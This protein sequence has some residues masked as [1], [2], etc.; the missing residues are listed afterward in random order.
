M[1]HGVEPGQLLLLADTQSPD[2]V[3]DPEHDGGGDDHPRGDGG[4]AD[5]LHAEQRY[6]ST[7][8][9]TPVDR[10]E[11]DGEDTPD[12][13]HPVH[14]D[15]AHRVVDTD[16]L[17][18]H[19]RDHHH[20]TSDRSDQDRTEGAD[21][22]GARGDG[23]ETGQHPVE[24]ETHVG[25]S[26]ERVGPPG[27]HRRQG[28]GR[29]GQRGGDD[30]MADVLAHR[31]E[32]RPGVEPVPAEPEDE[33]TKGSEQQRVAGDGKGVALRVVLADPGA[34]HQH[35]REGGK[36]TSH[37]DDTRPGEV[38]EA[39]VAQPPV[40][41]PHPV[42]DDRVDEAGDERGVEQVGR[43]LRAFR[44]RPR[45]DRG[46]GGCEHHLEEPLDRPVGVV[47]EEL[48]VA[49]EPLDRS[50]P[51]CQ[52]EPDRPVHEGA[53]GEVH[54]VLHD[55]VGGVLRPGEAGLHEG[56]PCLHE[57]DE[58]P[59]QHH[60]DGVDR[61]AD[62]L[63]G[64]GGS[65]ERQRS[66]QGDGSRRCH[67]GDSSSHP[68]PPQ[69]G[70]ELW[71]NG[72][73]RRFRRPF[74]PVAGTRRSCFEP[75]AHPR[76]CPHR[77]TGSAAPDESPSKYAVRHPATPCQRGANLLPDGLV[78]GTFFMVGPSPRSVGPWRWPG[79]HSRPRSPACPL[80]PST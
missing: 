11:A 59:G 45:D 28:A 72:M 31:G 70:C 38:G 23:D 44:H 47:E 41:A 77:T 50:A 36:A 15:G 21:G 75:V 78:L 26:V 35:A 43:E 55:D 13:H 61:R 63:D 64:L 48:A 32:R 24:G 74:P 30:H 42:G 52:A 19:D 49:D 65:G 39:E 51:I 9:E 37:V 10:E 2:G 79:R 76:S 1:L 4:H 12:P 33:H 40:A 7:G 14:R 34:E 22:G 69:W 71:R 8:E 67:D 18:S 29:C 57:H 60:P 27:D 66:D 46:R 16:P 62:L 68:G 53:G 5:R 25:F 80:R 56:E 20:Q 73:G 54:H 3:E 17:E 6:P 58:D